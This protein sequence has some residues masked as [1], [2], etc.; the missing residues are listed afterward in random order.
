MTNNE[1]VMLKHQKQV[2]AI[3]SM[4]GKIGVVAIEL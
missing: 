2:G 1:L 3:I 4:R